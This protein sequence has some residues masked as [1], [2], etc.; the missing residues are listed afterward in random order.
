MGA[1]VAP[2]KKNKRK[3]KRKPVTASNAQ[4]DHESGGLMSFGRWPKQ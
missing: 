4:E 1:S 2:E 3:K